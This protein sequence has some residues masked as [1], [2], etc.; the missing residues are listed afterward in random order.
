[1]PR[2][3]SSELTTPESLRVFGMVAAG[4]LTE[5]KQFSL[6]LYSARKSDDFLEIIST[7]LLNSLSNLKRLT[8][9]FPQ[10]TL[11]NSSDIK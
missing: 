5:L 9:S 8:L 4:R 2:N 10:Y 7:H 6:V 3:I 1:M 11:K